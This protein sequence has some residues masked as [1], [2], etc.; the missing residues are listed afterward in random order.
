MVTEAIGFAVSS[1]KGI[2]KGQRN[3]VNK[4]ALL[5]SVRTDICR[6]C[7]FRNLG[8]STKQN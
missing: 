1:S 4:E 6:E 7:I 5:P 2:Y 3:T 8:F